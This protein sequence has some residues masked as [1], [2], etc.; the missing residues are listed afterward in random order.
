MSHKQSEVTPDILRGLFT[1]NPEAGTL[2]HKPRQRSAFGNQ[3][4][5]ST[6]TSKYAGKQAFQSKN[7]HGYPIG[8]IL[9]FNFKAHRV[10]WAIFHGEWPQDEIDHINHDRADFRIINLRVVTKLENHKN[11]STAITNKSGYNGVWYSKGAKKWTAQITVE[12][13]ASHL[14]YFPDM[15]AAV[16]ARKAAELRLGFHVNHGAINAG[17]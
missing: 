17:Q 9:G 6:W 7:E 5:F 13:K 14:G 16:S 11:R 4:A 3:R 1:Y 15:A 12:R 10:A 8:R 2:S